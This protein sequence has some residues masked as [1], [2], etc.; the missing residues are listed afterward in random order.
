MVYMKCQQGV[1]HVNYRHECFDRCYRVG[2]LLEVTAVRQPLGSF[3]TGVKGDPLKNEGRE[4]RGDNNPIYLDW[5]GTG[6]PGETTC[7]TRE[8]IGRKLPPHICQTRESYPR[9]RGAPPHQ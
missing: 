1:D 8:E 4:R 5:W 9:H 7:R 2:L 3:T 6:V